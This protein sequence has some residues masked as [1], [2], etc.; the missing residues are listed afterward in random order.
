VYL[1]R[2]EDDAHPTTPKL[3]IDGIAA[4]QRLLEGEEQ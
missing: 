2:Q 3:A 4:G 1:A